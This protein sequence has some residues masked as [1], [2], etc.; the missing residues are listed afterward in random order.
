LAALA[1]WVFAPAGAKNTAPQYRTSPANWELPRL[2]RP[3]KLSLA[4][5]HGKPL[6][7]NFFATWCVACRSELP[8]LKTV[9][10]ELKDKVTFV[11]VNSQDFGQ[12]LAMAKEFKID[13][14]PLAKDVGGSTP[15][16]SGFHDALGGRGMPVTVFYDAS[17]KQVFFAG[18]ALSE[19]AFA[20]KLNDLYGVTV[21]AASKP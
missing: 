17:G 21:S 14:W 9:S 18:G 20:Q 5:F 16:G 6:V 10:E 19:R 13:W 7:V 15:G 4:Q 1:F 11:G 3:G 8:G 2:D 12:G